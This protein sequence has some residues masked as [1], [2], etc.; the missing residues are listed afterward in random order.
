MAILTRQA[1]A[2][3]L[4]AKADKPTPVAGLSVQL[5]DRLQTLPVSKD[6]LIAVYH[7]DNGAPYQVVCDA[8]AA[9]TL[10]PVLKLCTNV[11]PSTRTD[12]ARVQAWS[13][14]A[15]SLIK[16]KPNSILKLESGHLL[17]VACADADYPPPGGGVQ[18]QM[19]LYVQTGAGEFSSS[20]CHA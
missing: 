13:L 16:D 9:R 8:P 5:F 11:G 18:Y 19:S 17:F 2:L 12:H 15:E 1:K 20:Q 4:R 14:K 6:P 3:G 7:L 10:D